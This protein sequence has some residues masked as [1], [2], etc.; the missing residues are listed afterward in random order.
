MQHRVRATSSTNTMTEKKTKKKK[1]VKKYSLK[2]TKKKKT[3]DLGKEVKVG[4]GG[5]EQDTS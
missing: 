3:S 4:V 2:K 5:S 1:T